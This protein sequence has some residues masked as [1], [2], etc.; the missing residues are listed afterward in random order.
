MFRKKSKEI[1]LLA[2]MTFQFLNPFSNLIQR[3]YSGDF[4]PKNTYRKRPVILTIIPK[5]IYLYD[6]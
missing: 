4:D 3:P 5:A 1:F 6:K 2:L